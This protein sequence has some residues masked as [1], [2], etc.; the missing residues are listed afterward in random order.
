MKNNFR[1]SAIDALMSLMQLHDNADFTD[2]VLREQISQIVFLV[3]PQ[4]SAV[5]IKVCQEETY[6][7]SSVVLS[8]VKALG[9]FLCLVFEDYEKKSV[10]GLTSDD[11]LALVSSRKTEDNRTSALKPNNQT[12]AE[13]I[14]N[15][16]KTSRWLLE[17]SEKIAPVVKT[18]GCLRGS[19]KREIRRELAIFSRNLL[20]KCLPNIEALVSFLLENLIT[21]ADD[22]D[23]EIRD[24]SQKS[25]EQLAELRPELNEEIVEIFCLHLMSM[26]RI[27][28]TG[29]ESEQ[30]SGFTLLNSLV[31]IITSDNDQLNSLMNNQLLLD[32]LLNVLLSC[33]E[34]E[35]DHELMFYENLSSND[36]DDRFYKIRKPWKRY[37]NLKTEAV[38]KKFSEVCQNI[39]RSKSAETF[40]NYLQDDMNSVEYLALLIEVLQSGEHSTIVQDQVESLVEEFLSDTYW[41]MQ[42]QASP[43]LEPTK[44]QVNEEWFH[45]NT[46]GLYESAVEV[47]LKDVPMDVD[48]APAEVTL[49]T[50]KY[51]ILCTCL[52]LELVGVAAS[53]LQKKFQRFLLPSMHRVL[54]KAGSS[55]FIIRAAGIFALE[56]IGCAMDYEGIPQLIDDNS[57]FILFN[58]Q[59]LMKRRA[60][61][62]KILD[63]LSVVFRF[64]KSSMT[65]YIK[66]IVETA[67]VQMTQKKFANKVISYL[68]LFSLYAS[69][70]RQW[71]SEIDADAGEAVTDDFSENWEEFF[72]ECQLELATPP[73]EV[74]EECSMKDED[75]D[76]QHDESMPL[77]VE[78]EPEKPQLPEHIALIVKIMTSSLQFFASSN[79]TEV[80]ATHEIFTNCLPVLHR[81]ED[82][83]LPVIHQMWY[84]FT[85]QFRVK[86]HVTLQF[87]FRLLELIAR[88][89][90]DFIHNRSTGDVIPVINSFLAESL[91]ANKATP[92]Y[93]QEFKLQREILAGYGSLAVSLDLQ[94]KDLDD[95]VDIL[96][97][98]KTLS[99]EGL[100]AACDKSLEVLEKHDPGLVFF[101]KKYF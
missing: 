51:N 42:V 71:D 5:L 44:K 34:I 46:P 62:E 38:A 9:R 85:K 17:A 36:L 81:Y 89:A 70:V 13:Y 47:R 35:I 86:N 2:I 63:M 43:S 57:R 68:K 30:I 90:K 100:A 22:A 78:P 19:D 18:I 37:K 28:L 65:S 26:P 91:K 69:S 73:D 10:G 83:F 97:S 95:I 60:D 20:E 25:L 7:G 16:K 96:L 61:N 53:V 98:Y 27:V 67:A 82:D 72:E 93:A 66:D 58:I 3:L 40:V 94:E 32:R 29:D 41:S 74:I 24:F 79:Q 12:Q 33:C 31:F 8:G 55:N 21:L 56:S 23:S 76:Q 52:V 64:S 4:I 77:D 88:L 14:A 6:K 75:I 92:S 49:K 59:L 80:I 1:K 84:P 15:L 45:E 48:E 101:K 99:N 54:E 39:G 11:F 87:S 50:I